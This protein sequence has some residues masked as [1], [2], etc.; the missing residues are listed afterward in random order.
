VFRNN[1]EAISLGTCSKHMRYFTEE[2]LQLLRKVY[3]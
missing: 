2:R 3:G 1:N